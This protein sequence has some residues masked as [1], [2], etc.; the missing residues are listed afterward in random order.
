MRSR[1]QE[2]RG[3]G[4]GEDG[5]VEVEKAKEKTRKWKERIKDLEDVAV[6]NLT[7]AVPIKSRNRDVVL[8]AVAE[9]YSRCRAAGSQVLRVRTDRAREFSQLSGRGQRRGVCGVR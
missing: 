3:P 2:E 7:F 5:Q 1:T 9:C 6:H 8:Q 4:P